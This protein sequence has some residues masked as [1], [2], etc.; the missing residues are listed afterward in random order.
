VIVPSGKLIRPFKYAVIGICGQ[1]IDFLLT[2]ALANSL[3]PLQVANSAGYISGSF[4]A[5]IG[6]AKYTFADQ[7]SRLTSLK[8]FLSFFVACLLGASAGSVVLIFLFGLGIK[9]EIAKI[10]QLFVIAVV[11]YFLN[12]AVTFAK[13]KS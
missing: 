2:I 10:S 4:F 13:K 9:L 5:Y 11:Q 3:V 7:A 6:H 8:Q 12:C 1:Y